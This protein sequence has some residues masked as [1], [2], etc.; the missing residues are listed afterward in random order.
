MGG[1]MRGMVVAEMQFCHDG[2]NYGDMPETAS[3][4]PIESV[5]CPLQARVLLLETDEGR[6][7]ILRGLL[8]SLSCRVRTYDLSRETPENLGERPW[9]LILC[10]LSLFSRLR[11][12]PAIP[13]NPPLILLAPY[14]GM[15][16]ARELVLGG[17]A[18]DW[19]P[20]PIREGRVLSLLRSVLSRKH[21]EPLEEARPAGG[22]GDQDGVVSV[23]GEESADALPVRHFGLMVGESPR[24]QELYRQIEKVSRAEMTV[25]ILGESGTG[26][27]LVAKAIHNSG[28]R[29][30][31]PFVP[32]NCSSLP[33]NL[34]ES[35]LFGYVK[36]AFT[37]AVHNKDG[38]FVAAEGGTLFL[39]EVGS[40]APSTQMALLRALQ[41][42]EIRPV[43]SVTPRPVNVR[44]VAATNED[45]DLLRE[46]GK[47]RQDL[48]YR[49]S[50]FTLRLPALRE[51]QGDL[52]LLMHSF[53][54][55][56]P[57]A[58]GRI[59]GL[60][61]AAREALERHR[62]PGNVRELL[63]V[64]QRGVTLSEGDAIRL[65]DLP[66]EF[67]ASREGAAA[68]GSPALPGVDAAHPQT[69]KA[70]LRSCERQYLRRVLE[71][72]HGNKEEAAKIL[73][74][75]VATLYRK[76]SDGA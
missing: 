39:D 11:G 43:G 56:N 15:A 46:Q 4:Q 24:M 14:D 52:P 30:N 7:E 58:D 27:E 1:V 60:S 64:L 20:S 5:S 68:S 59:R 26:K 3:E 21:E 41:E 50:A 8:R 65:K 18:T 71:E 42:R 29:A 16:R 53:L 25:L 40:I 33:E 28:D 48:F 72:F 17:E 12:L 34:L 45:V 35:E 13:G 49:L 76:L 9:D 37:G 54:A 67:S 36:G 47:L 70:Y 75:S 69:L 74:I 2:I 51:R 62:W 38:L 19:L 31:K 57:G 23:V 61:P 22:P 55:E 32:V 10:D 66:Q 44:V 73:G 63:H 6:G